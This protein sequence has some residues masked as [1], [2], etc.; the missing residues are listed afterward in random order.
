MYQNHIRTLLKANLFTLTFILAIGLAGILGLTPMAMA[1]V[2]AQTATSTPTPTVTPTP[3]RRLG[4]NFWDKALAEEI[5]PTGTQGQPN[6]YVLVDQSDFD[7]G[8]FDTTIDDI[9]KMRLMPIFRIDYAQG[10]AVPVEKKEFKDWIDNNFK[11]K[12]ERTYTKVKGVFNNQPVLYI[13]GN[14]PGLDG[15]ITEEQYA[16]AYAALWRGV[17][18]PNADGNPTKYT[19]LQLL[20]AGQNF[21]AANTNTWAGAVSTLIVD[22]HADVDGYALHTYGF[23]DDTNDFILPPTLPPADAAALKENCRHPNRSC[24][25]AGGWEGDNSFKNY[26]DQLQAIDEAGFDDR[27]VYITEFNTFTGRTEAKQAHGPYVPSGNYPYGFNWIGEAVEEVEA[28]GRV[29][30]LLWFVGPPYGGTQQNPDWQYFALKENHFRLDCA[31]RDFRSVARGEPREQCVWEAVVPKLQA[32]PYFAGGWMEGIMVVASDNESGLNQLTVVASPAKS[33]DLS[34]TKPGET[35]TGI[36]DIVPPVGGYATLTLSDR[37]GNITQ[38]RVYNPGQQQGGSDPGGDHPD[39][40]ESAA[41]SLLPGGQFF[42]LPAGA[43]PTLQV[44]ILNRGFAGNLWQAL[45]KIG[46]PAALINADFDPAATAR[47]YPVLLIPSGGLYGLENSTAFRK[48]LELYAEAGGTIVAFAQQHGYEFSVLPGT[49]SPLA[50][51]PAPLS[52]YGWQEDNSCY[53]ASL[54][55][56]ANHPSL[57]GFSQ[58]AL[59]A[60]VDGYFSTV[61]T[62]TTTLLT[63]NQNGAPGAILYP[64][65][66]GRVIATSMYDDWG[67]ANGQ[68]S[69]GAQI[70]LRDLVSWAVDPADNIPTYAP[71]ATVSLSASVTNNTEDEITAIQLDLINPARE[72]VETQVVTTTLAPGA[73]TTLSFTSSPVASPLGIWRLDA[74]LLGGRGLPISPRVPVGRF[75]VANPPQ[76]IAS[77]RPFNLNIT[78]P[79]DH[80]PKGSRGQFTFHVFN[81][82]DQTHTVTVRYGLPHHTWE[83]VTDPNTGSGYGSFDN[84]SQELTVLAHSEATFVYSPTLYTTDRLWARLDEGGQTQANAHFAV[85]PLPPE[86]V[87]ITNVRSV[88]PVGAAGTT[89]QLQ[90]DLRNTQPYTLSELIAQ[91]SMVDTEGNLVYSQDNP[92]APMLPGEV[93]QVDTTFTMPPGAVKGVASI[94]LNVGSATGRGTFLISPSPLSSR[95]PADLAITPGL[96]QTIPLLLTN[97][98]PSL[99]VTQ[100]QASLTLLDGSTPVATGSAGFSLAGGQELT[101]PIALEVPLLAFDVQRYRLQVD[102]SDEYDQH[103]WQMALPLTFS[104]AVSFDRPYARIRETAAVTLTLHNPGP[105]VQALTL[106]LTAPDLAFVETRSATLPAGQ[107]LNQT[108]T[109]PIPNDTSV[110]QYPLELTASLV[111]SPP[112]SPPLISQVG[113]VYVPESNLQASSSALPTLAGDTFTI[114]IHNVGGVDTTADYNFSIYDAQRQVIAT[115]TGAQQSVPVDQPLDLP[116]TLPG[117]LKNGHYTLLGTITN[118]ATGKV[119][120]FYRAFDLTGLALQLTTFTDAETYL[121]TAPIETTAIITN[122]AGGVALNSGQ[123]TMRIV[124][125]GPVQSAEWVVYTTNDSGLADDTVTDVAVDGQGNKWFV[126]PQEISRLLP[127]GDWDNFLYIEGSTTYQTMAAAGDWVWVGT[128]SGAFAFDGTG[129]TWLEAGEGEDN[130][131][132]QGQPINDVV[133]DAAGRVWFATDGNG[134][135]VLNPNGTPTNLADDQWAHFTSTDGLASDYP[136]RLTFD[137]VGY[138]W[139]MSS[140]SLTVFD[141]G[142]DL[143]DPG[144]DAWVQLTSPLPYWQTMMALTVDAAGHIWLGASEGLYRLND[145]GTNPFENMGDDSWTNY[146]AYNSNLINNYIHALAF[147]QAGNLWIGTA[148]GLSLLLS[149]ERWRNYTP[150]DGLGSGVINAIAVDAD[151]NRWLVTGSDS[152]YYENEYVNLPGGVTAAIGSGLPESSWKTFTEN[153]SG[154]SDDYLEALAADGAGNIW[155]VGD[156]CSGGGGTSLPQKKGGGLA[157]PLRD[158]YCPF[159]QRLAPGNNWTVFDPPFGYYRSI[160][161]MVV[162]VTG[163]VWIAVDD[164]GDTGELYMLSPQQNTWETPRPAALPG[165]PKALAVTGTT[166]WAAFDSFQGEGFN[167]EGIAVYSLIDQTWTVVYRGSE[168]PEVD[169]VE[170]R[171]LAI[172]PTGEVWVATN[173]GVWLLANGDTWLTYDSTQPD[174]LV[175]D[176]VRAIAIDRQ[177]RHWFATPSGTSVLSMNGSQWATFSANATSLAVDNQ[178]NIWFG[179]MSNSGGRRLDYGASPFDQVEDVWTEYNDFRDLGNK[180]INDIAVDEAGQ[181]WLATTARGLARYAPP[182]SSVGQVLWQHTAVMN[183]GSPETVQEAASLTAAELGATGKLYLEADLAT[184]LDQPLGSTR[185]PFYIF[186]TQTRLTL[187]SDR[188]IYQPGQAMTL[189]GRIDNGAASPL[190]GQVLTVT[191]NGQTVY[192]E[193]NLTVLAESSYPFTV[194]TTAPADLGRILVGAALDDLTV[195]DSLVVATPALDTLLNAPE[196]ADHAPFDLRLTLTNLGKLDLDLTAT[197]DGQ[198]ETLTLPAGETKII[199]GTK[200]IAAATVVTAQVSGDVTASVTRTVSMGEAAAVAFSPEPLYSVGR[201]EIPYTLT[202]TG[203]LPLAFPLELALYTGVT[204]VQSTTLEVALPMSGTISGLLTFD[205]PAG[206]Y[207]L[208]YNSS[209]A[210]GAVNWQVAALDQATLEVQAQTPVGAEIPLTVTV[211]NTGANTL[212]GHIAVETDFFSGNFDFDWEGSNLLQPGETITPSVFVDTTNAAPGSHPVTVTVVAANG[213]VLA[214]QVVTVTVSSPHLTF[215]SLPPTSLPLI[216]GQVVTLTFEVENSGGSAGEALLYVTLADFEDESQLLSLEPGESGSL[217]FSFYLPPE[218]AAGDYIATYVLSD[219]TTGE[220]QQSDLTL[221]VAGM[222]LAITATLDKAV[223][224]PGETANLTLDVSNQ[225]DRPTTNLYALARFGDAVVTQTFS[226]AG[227]G[228]QTFN[229]AIPVAAE[230][231]DDTLFY[232]IYDEGSTR[233]VYLNTTHLY[234]LNSVAALYPSQAVYSPGATVQVTVATTATGSLLV[235]APGYS[236]TLTLNGSNT[237]FSFT[238]PGDLT[239]GTYTIDYTLEGFLPRSAA[240]DVAGPWV[241]VTEARLVDPPDAPGDPLQLA[242]TI[243]S[244]TSEEVDVRAWLLFP[245]GTQSAA[246]VN[247]LSL[248]TRLNNHTSLQLPLA[249]SQA[250]PYR[251]VYQLTAPGQPDR[252]YASGVEEFDVGDIAVL[253]L[254]TAQDD[255]LEA[256]TPVQLVATLVASATTAA[257]VELEVDGVEVSSQGVNLTPGSQTIT[258]SA[259]DVITPGWH[260]ARVRLTAG[261]LS[262]V[263]ETQFVYNAFGPDLVVRSPRLFKPSGYTATLYTYVYNLGDQP[264]PP[265]A[266]RLYD[267]DPAASG[268]LIAEVAVPSMPA[269]KPFYNDTEEFFVTWDVTGLAGAHTVYLVADAGQ[270]VTEIN[271]DNNVSQAEVEVPAL[272]LVVSTDQETYQPGE[273]VHMTV[274]VANLQASGNLNITLTTTTDLLGY[275]PFQMTEP[276]TVPAGEWVERPYT[277]PVTATYGGTYNLIA[278]ATGDIDP[279]REYAQFTLP[280]GAEFTAAPLTGTVPLSVTFSD[281]SSPWGWVETWQWDFGD[282]SASTESNPVHLYDL[283]GNYTVTLTTTVGLSTYVKTKPGYITVTEVITPAASFGT[284]TITGLIPMTV[285]FTDTSTGTVITRTWDFGDSTSTVVTTSV[286]VSHTYTLAGVYT[287]TLTVEGPLGSDVLTRAAYILAVAPQI[288]GTFALEAEDYARQIGGADLTWQIRTVHPGYSGSGYVQARPDVD[289]L[290]TTAPISASAE[291]HY[292][293]GLTITGTYTVWLRGYAA[294]SAGDSVYVGLDGQPILAGDYVSAYPPDEWAWG[295]TL[296]ESGQPIT[297]TVDAPGAHVLHIWTREDGFSLDQIILTNE[298]TFTPDD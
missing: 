214:T 158:G 125:A 30:G 160:P 147:D 116:I 177:G 105:F 57:S 163:H 37:A 168:D 23:G 161:D 148:Q 68:L 291:L 113:A 45:V 140:D 17:H 180:Y 32:A 98:N 258:L 48:R 286:A 227:N 224:T 190:A 265:S 36:L 120:R 118:Q 206:D 33:Y 103:T 200:Q 38:Q 5:F 62:H 248:Q 208:D 249:T 129:Q 256:T 56:A 226:L 262:S 188:T 67:A 146:T 124:N 21:H 203:Q 202:N 134:L 101:L 138:V 104:A 270:A 143:F 137:G 285:T 263:A 218:L 253:S 189:T 255:Y 121:T 135:C 157:S 141:G 277:W 74:T 229:L 1:E 166:V 237:S 66:Q 173:R 230:G 108:Y 198:A 228:A 10:R 29:Q 83:I 13:V 81:N 75:I 169:H 199:T 156:E 212:S 122:P 292:G 194:T 25:G 235:R 164:Y 65:G 117:Q 51:L 107:D 76:T 28:S 87:K 89:V 152:G 60:H 174:T 58:T 201:V 91:W 220:V 53:E 2:T 298:A 155:L 43:R 131:C 84:L 109:I 142:D 73:S 297:F 97:L 171:D 162:D 80:F 211:T 170:F 151:G 106:T 153:N 49:S 8:D 90:A 273:P 82:T 14:E 183:A 289:A 63:R 15:E 205:L 6:G 102:L 272:S 114:T 196:L 54:L 128:N 144:D 9:L 294:N 215:I 52:A 295:H 240:F 281:L 46:E 139:I 268:Q 35:Y 216:P 59:T 250:G 284:D 236:Q 79:S 197:L 251:L 231:V 172:A 252:V 254:H 259:S 149:G 55:L 136:T 85:F 42:T 178:G 11:K 275:K 167:P 191:I 243:A 257:Q 61:P 176:D 238:L 184:S 241:R 111:A 290:F 233:G 93:S 34:Q 182:A 70:F 112:T 204:L 271:E 20:I 261:G 293:L 12:I 72:I 78:A 115:V 232:G 44:A 99:D 119:T 71:G 207:R 269:K 186:P 16:T 282:G 246:T 47:Q 126:H 193:T 283:P 195:E 95:F 219:T 7:R 18:E 150:L 175:S 41:S 245:D 187:A 267:G 86:M 185:S 223:Y 123:L 280:V 181:V 213:A 217:D 27:P 19:D 159:V 69:D 276:V 3:Y 64:Y 165:R 266:L 26:L 100:G 239:R 288:S 221:T 279:V 133:V 24:Y 94:R 39:D 209:Y 132:V 296:V 110:G 31:R 179:N 274:G 40:N 127:G 287:P 278:E 145:G 244:E 154:L 242:L 22:K 130:L 50:S 88:P 96:S 92:L 234:R 264:S 222:D 192:T 77:N 260:T 4:I 247:S 225:V 210:A